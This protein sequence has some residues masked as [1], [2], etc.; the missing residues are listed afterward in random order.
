MSFGV[1]KPEWE[2]QCFWTCSLCSDEHAHNNT[3]LN[4]DTEIYSFIQCRYAC[5]SA[6]WAYLKGI[7]TDFYTWK[8]VHRSWNE[9]RCT[10]RT[11]QPPQFVLAECWR[12]RNAQTDNSAL[13]AEFCCRT[14][15]G[16]KPREASAFLGSS[17]ST[18]SHPP[19]TL[20]NRFC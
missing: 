20:I 10:Y 11:E 12:A 5:Q 7:S 14:I 15:W 4:K 2:L 17:L 8:S 13:E 1:L 3:A 9:V 6:T 19:L 18:W 16:W